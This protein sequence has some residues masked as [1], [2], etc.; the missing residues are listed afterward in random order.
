ML[1]QLF[2]ADTVDC[3]TVLVT[4]VLLPYR[5]YGTT[6][7]IAGVS[8]RYFDHLNVLIRCDIKQK[9]LVYSQRSGPTL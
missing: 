6:S 5:S 2:P 3:F 8:C 4:G 9:L 1:R 7:V